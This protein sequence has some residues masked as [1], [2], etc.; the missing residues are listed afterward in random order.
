ML[1]EL[2]E[3]LWKNKVW[4]LVPPVIIFAIFGVLIIFSSASPVSSFVYMLF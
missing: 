1:K 3:Y 4:W 2:F